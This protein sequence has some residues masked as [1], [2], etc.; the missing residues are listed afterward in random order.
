MLELY[1]GDEAKIVDG[2]DAV[3]PDDHG[4]APGR[5]VLESAV[6]K[7]MPDPAAIF[8]FNRTVARN[9]EVY[10]TRPFLCLLIHFNEP[11]CCNGTAKK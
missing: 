6:L 10:S 2:N 9:F 5:N 3:E 11:N 4:S 1:L 7:T 8:T